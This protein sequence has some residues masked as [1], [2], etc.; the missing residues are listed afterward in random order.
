MNVEGTLLFEQPFARVPYENYRK[1]F[2]ATQRALEKELQQVQ[3]AAADLARRS[4]SP[5]SSSSNLAA[6]EGMI[7]KVEGLKRKVRTTQTIT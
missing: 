2:R 1:V 5:Q 4:E 7:A 6:V 3:A